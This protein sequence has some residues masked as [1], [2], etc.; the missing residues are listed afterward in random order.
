MKTPIFTFFIPLLI[1]C[2]LIGCNGDNS[3]IEL[4]P[5]MT[6]FLEMI[7]GSSDDV[8]AALGKFGASEEI[9]LDDMG[10]YDL[11][12]PKVT[13]KNGECYSVEFNYDI[14]IRMYDI[15]WADGKII[16]ISDKGIK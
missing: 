13:S 7:K 1:F 3:D 11:K 10:I 8:T 15:C 2:I 14:T 4:S 16:S 9:K 5:E 6:E 12:K